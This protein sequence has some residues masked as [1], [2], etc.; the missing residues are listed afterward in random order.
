MIE[1]DAGAASTWSSRRASPCGTLDAAGTDPDNLAQLAERARTFGGTTM[2][3]TDA[4]LALRAL[5]AKATLAA[6]LTTCLS[7]TARA[8]QPTANHA[9]A[10]QSSS[11]RLQALYPSTRFGEIRPTPWPGVSSRWRW[12]P[13]SPTWT[14]AASTSC[15]ATC[16]T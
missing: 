7:V 6:A 9:G 10:D 16:T 15:S 1:V 3:T 12:A 5:A 13:A 4:R 8:A 2:K 11:G 14:R